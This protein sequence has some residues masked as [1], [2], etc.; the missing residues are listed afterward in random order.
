MTP[1][2]KNFK[3]LLTL[4][5]LLPAA[6]VFQASSIPTSRLITP[7]ELVKVLRSSTGEKP[8]LIQVGFHILYTQGHIPDSEYIGPASN[9][10]GLQQLRKRVASLPRDKSI[11][12]YCGCCPWEHCPNVKRADDALHALGFTR[13]RVLYL[14]GN[15]A[16]EWMDKGYP[17][18]KGD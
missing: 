6:F 10:S 7:D 4:M 13:V 18:A 17:V 2:F 5:A 8:L 15:F 1:H 3:W 16:T 9:E 14:A 12:I 11:V